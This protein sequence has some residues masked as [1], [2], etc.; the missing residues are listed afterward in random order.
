MGKEELMLSMII[1]IAMRNN[2][3]VLMFSTNHRKQDYVHR[4]LSIRYDIPTSQLN[5]GLL[6][7][8]E[9]KRLDKEV[10][11]LINRPFFIYDSLDL[12]LNEL[13]ETIRKGV[14][15]TGARIVFVDCL[16]MIDF[17]KEAEN[18][19]ERIAKVMYSLKQLAC[20]YN[21]PIVVGSMLNREIEHREGIEG[22]LP[23]F[24]DFAN[25]SY[26]EELADVV[27]MVL[28]PE[29]YQIFQDEKGRDFHGV[30]NVVVMK[31]GLKQLGSCYLEYN[32]ETG[33]I[34]RGGQDDKSASN[35]V[36]LNETGQNN[37]VAK[38]IIRLFDCERDMP[39]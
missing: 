20:L 33:A 39:F 25:S 1:E 36:G 12:P 18:P 17:G 24:M 8:E 5:R 13:T 31:N 2:L 37:E 9:W 7:V 11:L 34:S 27:M 19:S 10:G 32:E 3:P 26:I 6:E 16:Q 30:M 38:K 14:S 22:K 23:Q 29:L 28:R 21:I 15:E 35:G 4:L